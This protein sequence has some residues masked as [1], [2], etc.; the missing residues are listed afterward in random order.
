[1]TRL[2][3]AKLGASSFVLVGAAQKHKG[4]TV[5]QLSDE[6]TIMERGNRLTEILRLDRV[7]VVGT[8]DYGVV[9]YIDDQIA[10]VVLDGGAR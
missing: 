4:N 3:F 7:N 1:M 8:G 9:Q 6:V 2:L 10:L 5:P